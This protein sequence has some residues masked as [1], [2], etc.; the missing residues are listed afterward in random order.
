MPVMPAFLVLTYF[1][2]L[3]YIPTY[4]RGLS[5]KARSCLAIVCMSQ[6]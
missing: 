3:T 5:E 1:I 6:G 4:I 2:A